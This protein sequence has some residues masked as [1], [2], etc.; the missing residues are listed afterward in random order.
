M[1]T[2]P[3]MLCLFLEWWI[4]KM[5]VCKMCD[6]VKC[7][8]WQ[9]KNMS[10]SPQTTLLLFL[11]SICL[12]VTWPPASPPR[13]SAP[14]MALLQ[15]QPTSF[16]CLFLCFARFTNTTTTRHVSIGYA[17]ISFTTRNT[18]F[19]I[20]STGFAYKKN[21]LGRSPTLPTL[22]FLKAYT[23]LFKVS[24]CSYC[25]KEWDTPCCAATGK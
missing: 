16:L 5:C 17:C 19:A 7:G 13:G 9:H 8:N 3:V 18:A 24:Q 10:F 2:E 6:V 11:S 20:F 4:L 15:T 1:R 23:P 25:C 21:S 14:L 22:A 12:E